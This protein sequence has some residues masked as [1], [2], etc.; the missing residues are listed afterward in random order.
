VRK[1]LGG[2]EPGLGQPEIRGKITRGRGLD[3]VREVMGLGDVISLL[4][5][6]CEVEGGMHFCG[7]RSVGGRADRSRH[8]SHR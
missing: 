2:G 3:Q 4:W 1:L 7:Q 8:R 5:A 6:E